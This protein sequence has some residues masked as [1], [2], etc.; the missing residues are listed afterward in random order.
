MTVESR[1][2]F[3]CKNPA[4]HSHKGGLSKGPRF[5]CPGQK[6]FQEY[7]GSLLSHQIYLTGLGQP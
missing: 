5:S 4:G 3:T 2:N 1:G 7:K 6:M